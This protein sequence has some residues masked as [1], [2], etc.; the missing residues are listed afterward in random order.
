MP[1]TM[2]L[3]LF[4]MAVSAWAAHI[5]DYCHKPIVSQWV[6]VDGEFYH[7]NHFICSNCLKPIG[8]QRYYFQN[9]R[10]YDSVCFA[11]FVTTRCDYCGKPIL[12]ES[13]TM[14]SKV[15][16]IEC[17]NRDIG[18][19]CVVCG[20]IVTGD[21]YV[22]SRGNTVCQEHKDQALRCCA[23]QQFL[24]PVE[25]GTWTKY[26]D[27]RVICN[28][29]RSTAVDN[30]DV[31]KKMV[32]TIKSELIAAGIV[33]DQDFKL[34]FVSLP[35]LADKFSNFLVD[36]LGV[37]LYEKSEMLGGLF[38]SR[39]FGIKILYGLPRAELHGVLAHEM[40]HVWLFTHAPQPQAPQL[41]E[42]SCQYAAYLVLKNDKSEDGRYFL[43]YLEKQDDEIYGDGFRN[44]RDYVDN[45][46][47][48]AW[49]QYLRENKDVPW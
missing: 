1:F 44:V 37:T 16:H 34:S 5:C 32:Q 27:G 20:R 29:C 3:A 33:V 30:I 43:D 35:E 47:L 40:M 7:P 36:H 49:L 14:N 39:K 2:L 21:F 38:T 45:I 18:K 13:I 24:S 23:C 25:N 48:S 22:D 10:Y 8:D 9:G 46:G 17:Y 41:C 26:T 28:Q 6:E 12:G 4:I 11:N 42:G 19:H 31:A 15:Y